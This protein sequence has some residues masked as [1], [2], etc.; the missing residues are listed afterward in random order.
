[1]E[2]RK[3]FLNSSIQKTVENLEFL[4]IFSF[5]III[6]NIYIF[7]F[8]GL[9]NSEI[10]S[11]IIIIFIF[12]F[13]LFKSGLRTPIWRIVIILSRKPRFFTFFSNNYGSKYRRFRVRST[14]AVRRKSRSLIFW[15][16]SEPLKP[17]IR[18]FKGNF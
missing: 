14:V 3:S 7:Q 17:L 15:S 16:Q 2:K 12:A 10:E 18:L 1:M 9:S 11:I 13:P 8:V 6:I 4:L 5:F